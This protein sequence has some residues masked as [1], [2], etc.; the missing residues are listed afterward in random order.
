MSRKGWILFIALCLIWGLPYLLIKVALREIDPGTLV[1][2]RTAPVAIILVPWV[3]VTRASVSLRGHLGWAA[4]Y[5]LVE[6]GMPWLL[7]TRAEQHLSSSLTALIVASVPMVAVL[8]S[9]FTHLHEPLG[10]SRLL[11]LLLGAAGVVLLVGLSF[12]GSNSLGLFEMSG[13]VVGYALGPLII[14][15]K[16]ADTS[17]TAVV[18]FSVSLVALFYMPFGLSHLPSHVSAEVLGAVIVLAL[19]CTA[20]AFLVFFSLIVEVGP[21]RS[22][23]V[24]FVNPAVAVVLGVVFLGEHLTSG[25]LLSFPLII[26][27]SVFA[28]QRHAPNGA[29]SATAIEP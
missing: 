20:M 17:G 12:G 8:F 2:L 21:A 14:A 23:V 19:V 16:L 7:M 3:I 15:T 13:V 22:T 29:G 25:M 1:F 28:T 5:A 6:F 18:A 4:A 11:G 24:T 9:R 26:L 10:L 27:G